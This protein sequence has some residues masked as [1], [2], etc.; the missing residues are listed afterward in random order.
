VCLP[1]SKIH[2]ALQNEFVKTLALLGRKLA[3]LSE[4]NIHLIQEIFVAD[5]CLPDFEESLDG[6]IYIVS[7]IA[8][9]KRDTERETG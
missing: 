4:R 1:L 8:V 6:C 3:D 2:P 9:K 5:T 7:E